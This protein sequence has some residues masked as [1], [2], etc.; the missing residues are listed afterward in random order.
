MS[1]FFGPGIRRNGLSLSASLSLPLSIFLLTECIQHFYGYPY[2][3]E[4][5]EGKCEISQSLWVVTVSEWWQPGPR[6]WAMTIIQGNYLFCPYLKWLPWWLRWESI[7]LQCRRPGFNPLVRKIPWR[8]EWEPT[9]VIW[10][11]NSM[12]RGAWWATVHGV[13]KNLTQLSN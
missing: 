7:W 9:P 5:T 3:D 12:D 11:A 4:K 8:R 13:R 1:D 6:V 10:L 2:I